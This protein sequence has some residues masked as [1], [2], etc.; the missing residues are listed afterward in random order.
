MRSSLLHLLGPLP[1]DLQHG[2]VLGPLLVLVGPGHPLGVYPEHG[3][4]G[5]DPANPEAVDEKPQP[6]LEVL[7]VIPL[8]VEVEAVL[9]LDGLERREPDADQPRAGVDRLSHD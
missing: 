8:G 9:L 7:A 5:L 3:Y 4:D 2:L 1:H 6:D